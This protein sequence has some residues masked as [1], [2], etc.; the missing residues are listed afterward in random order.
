MAKLNDL[1]VTIGAQTRQFDRALGSSM[2]KMQRFGMNTKKLGKSMTMGLTAPIAALGFTAVKAF[3]QQAKAIAQVEAGL[4]STGSTVGYTSKQLQQMASDLQTK[5]IFGDEEI[6]KDATSQLLTFT[7]IAGDQFARTQSVALDL[8]T[9]LDGDLKSA[10][11]QLGKALND[12][13]ANLSALSRSGIQFSEDQKQVIKSLTES[14]RLAEAQTVILD[15]LE[16]QYGGSAEAAAKAGT[17]GL[18]QLANSFGDL[19]EEFGKII[20]DFLPPVIDGLKNMLAAFQN[21]SPQAKKFLVIGGAIAAALGPL[22]A[23]LPAIISGLTLLT[24]PVGLVIAGI[25]GLGIAIVTF[26]DEIAPYITDVIN[27]FITLY[28]ESDA[29]RMLVGYVKAA[30]VQSF[31]NIWTVVGS[32]IDRVKDLGK[33]FMQVLSGDFEGA[34][35]TMKNGLLKTFDDLGGIV[36][37]T[38]AAIRDGINAELAKDPIELVN[39]ETVASAIKN[40]GGLRPLIND[41]LSGGGGGAGAAEQ[42]LQPMAAKGGTAGT[43]SPQLVNES[44]TAVSE[45]AENL[46][47]GRKEL[48][49]MVDMGPAVEGAFAGIGM[50]IGGLIAGTVQMSDIFSQAVLGLASLLIDLGQQFIAAGI[51]ASTFFVSLTTNPLA[52]VAAGVALV[53]AGAVIKGLSTRMQGSPPALAKGGLA[54]GPTMAMVGDNQNASVDPEVIAPLSKLQSMMGGQAVQVTGKISG[55]DILLTSEMSSIDRNRVRGY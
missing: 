4:K 36:T 30:F 31:K 23:I 18:K 28:N 15:E 24:G 3:D 51:A 13:I 45:L 29:V 48:S 53:A 50:A 12:P 27:Y 32:V 43:P 47:A 11:I 39:D 2:K 33:A 42:G 10:S 1:I 16:K 19:Q 5:T 26:A 49:M 44:S 20:M 54:F 40:L 17:G 6:L 38:A 41:L 8:A 21:L 34:F 52:A 35:E 37:D 22:L 9:R 14:G 55:R 46:K 7:N 25:V